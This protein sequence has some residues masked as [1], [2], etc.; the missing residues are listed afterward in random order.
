MDDKLSNI[1]NEIYRRKFEL[2]FNDKSLRTLD[3]KN[4]WKL[5]NRV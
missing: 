2:S 4:G 5:D 1:M 3:N